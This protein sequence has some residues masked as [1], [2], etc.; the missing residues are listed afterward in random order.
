L[1]FAVVAK[2]VPDADAVGFDP[3]RKTLRREAGPL[4]LNPFDQRALRV[5][6]ELKHPGDRVSVVSMGPG[7]A[8]PVLRETLALGADQATLITDPAL[9]GS[10]T[11][12]TARVLARYLTRHPAGL[13]LAGKWSTDSET[14]QVPSQLA[15]L[16]DR[17]LVT[18]ARRLVRTADGRGVDATVETDSGWARAVVSTPAVVSVGEKIAKPLHLTEEASQTLADRHVDRVRL[19]DLGLTAFQ[20]GLAGSPTSVGRLED[21]T[22]NRRHARFADGTIEQRVAG[23]VAAVRTVLSTSDPRSRS[24][25]LAARSGA[26][27]DREAFALVTQETG[28]I[29][30]TGVAAISELRRAVPSCRVV[31][32][33]VGARPS[34]VAT[35]RL[36]AAGAE[37]VVHHPGDA[38]I[39]ARNA[40]GAIARTLELRGK[41]VVG[42]FPSTEFGRQVA[43]RIAA[44]RGLGLTGDVVGLREIPGGEVRFDKPAFGGGIVAEIACRTV[45]ALATVR[46]GAFAPG[47][48]PNPAPLTP[49]T[50]VPVAS[51][52][53][54]HWLERSDDPSDGTADPASARIILS[55]GVGA[56]TPEAIATVRAAAV[57]LGAALVGTRR[58]VDAGGLPASRQVGLTGH[59]VAPDLGVLL[60]VRGSANHM[61]GWRR[62]HALIAVDRDPEAAVFGGVDAGVVGEWADALPVLV[63]EIRSLPIGGR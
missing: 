37:E 16:L 20:V 19:S 34:S 15:E 59:S 2:V 28:A 26:T 24:P 38:G 23:A 7:S 10:D 56:G 60:G 49:T 32:L 11:L 62:A 40:A 18:A 47:V 53:S 42:L 44:R 41:S 8:E 5:A 13:I 55:V 6:L 58:V 31:A 43:G 17:P 45:P 50:G 61:I 14:G 35:A 52:L 3:D 46:P 33:W 54:T 48:V 25:L 30:P 51:D 27:G 4:F 21:R 36:A 9:A 29:D 63:R 1:E 12:V 22:P 57:S 39:T